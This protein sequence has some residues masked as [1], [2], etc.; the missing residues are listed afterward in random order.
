MRSIIAIG[1]NMGDRRKYI[2]RSLEMI[3]ERVGRIIASSDI[4]ETEPYGNVDQD[5]FLNMAVLIDTELSPRDLLHTLNAIEAELERKRDIRWGPRTIDLDIILYGEEIIDEEDLHIPHIDMTRRD[6]VL[7]PASQVAPDMVDPR[8]GKTIK[9]LFDD[10]TKAA[11]PEAATPKAAE[12]ETPAPGDG[13]K[14]TPE[15]KEAV[16]TD[17][18]N[19]LVSAA[20][21]S[22]KTSVL[23]ERI[24]RLIIDEEVDVDR[25]LITTFTN[26][27]AAEMKERLEKRISKDLNSATGDKRAFLQKQIRLLPDAHIETFHSFAISIIRDY[28]FLTDIQPGFAIGDATRVNM[29]VRE[30]LDELFERRFAEDTDRFKGFLRKYS[31]ERN[32]FKIKED[33]R[34]VYKEMLSIPDYMDWAK[35]SI[36]CLWENSPM[37]ALGIGEIIITK[38]DTELEEAVCDFGQAEDL[39]RSVGARNL[40]QKTAEDRGNIETIHM[41]L[42][43]GKGM[44]LAGEA[45]RALKFNSMRTNKDDDK[46][47][48]ARVKEEANAARDRGKA[49]VKALKEKFFGSDLD[50]DDDI[51]KSLAE[52]TE[53]FLGL[54]EELDSILGAGKRAENIIDFDDAMHY[55]IKILDDEKAAEDYKNRFRYIFIDEYQDSNYLQ[56]RIV[57]RIAGKGNLFMVGDVKQSIYKFRLAEPEI[58]RDKYRRFMNNEEEDSIKIDLNNNFRSKGNIRTAV[59]AVF[60]DVME[61]YDENAALKGPETGGPD[62]P[63]VQLHV[64]DGAKKKEIK[65]NEEESLDDYEELTEADLVEKI[66]REYVGTEYIDK[67]GKS[68]KLK[69]GDIAVLSRGKRA[70]AWMEN[71][72]NNADIPACGQTE[73]GYYEVVEISVFINLLKVISNFRQ[74][75]PLITAMSAMF[76]GFTP[77]ELARIR[78]ACRDGAYCDAVISYAE[79]GEDEKLRSKVQAMIEDIRRWKE[80]SRTVELDELMRILIYETGYYDYCSS[81]PVGER[82]VSNLRLLLE[83]AAA[84]E[85]NSHYGLYGFLSY[86][87]AMKSR[88]QQVDEAPLVGEGED[89]VHVMTVH[90]SKGLEFPMVILIGTGKEIGGARLG[91]APTVHK[92]F[93]IALPYVDRDRHFRSK[94]LLQRTIA[95]RKTSEIVEEEIRILYVAMTRAMDR[96]VMIGSVGSVDK[97]GEEPSNKSFI[98]MMWP[99]MTRLAESAPDTALVEVHEGLLPL[100]G[101]AGADKEESA[102]AP[103]SGDAEGTEP[104]GAPTSGDEAGDEPADEGEPEPAGTAG[105][106]GDEPSDAD[107]AEIARRLSFEYPY[108]SALEVRPKY[109]VTTLASQGTAT[110]V[111]IPKLRSLVVEEGALD[112]AQRGTVMHL[113]MERIDFGRA[114]SEGR[115]YIDEA[116][117]AMRN[118]DILTQIEYEAVSSKDIAAFFEDPVGERAAKAGKLSRE[119]EFIMEETVDG[120]PAVVQGV[121]DCWFEEDDGLVIIDYKNSYVD[122]DGDVSHIVDRYAPQLALYK[123]ALEEAEEKPV[124]EAWLYLFKSGKFV[125]VDI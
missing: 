19:I 101:V 4:I 64:I 113:I 93:T 24:S 35:R 10:L 98:D 80:I 68:Q 74:D 8:T 11:E 115:D 85:K 76:F 12:P 13:P 71:H 43:N 105:A 49:R 5:D 119:K 6:F 79:S 20:A 17:G 40:C 82:R 83:K 51:M 87:E 89:V 111:Q 42:R 23:V 84:F 58:F 117:A 125:S 1:S 52:D 36:R 112:A 106:G 2:E 118:E 14:W 29:M 46:E 69:Y 60:A 48:Y 73:G 96:L 30:S 41:M 95:D 65:N 26:S 86:V 66:I 100:P 44:D 88:R 57:E 61:G 123:K 81:L 90:K 59:N 56:E 70:V 7:E 99:A 116:A 122:D 27:A 109:S 39:L 28:F 94:T 77:T 72:L 15:Q 34:T 97:L 22:G 78:I 67:G 121:I 102:G 54:I 25:F 55:A 124:K 107:R 47:G 91:F 33:I 114:Y 21:G 92:D 16:E 62:G 18:A 45:L 50:R 9:E 75:V 103:T 63:S 104:A 3:E 31:S 38:A 53:Y 108:Q 32:D 120:E 37:E 110:E